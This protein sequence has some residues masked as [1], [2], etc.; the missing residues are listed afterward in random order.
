VSFH[1]NDYN[2]VGDELNMIVVSLIVML[3]L[4]GVTAKC[5][6]R[7]KAAAPDGLECREPQSDIKDD[8][9]RSGKSP[10]YSTLHAVITMLFHACL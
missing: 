9:S 7:Q 4:A 3:K 5:N 6:A 1:C 10:E 2:D 8:I